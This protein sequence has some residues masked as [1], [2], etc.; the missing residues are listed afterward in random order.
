MPVI[1]D[2]PDWW[3]RFTEDGLYVHKFSLPAQQVFPEHKIANVIEEEF[4]SHINQP[5]DREVAKK[6]KHEVKAGI[7]MLQKSSD[8]GGVMSQQHLVY[9]A[10]HGLRLLGGTTSPSPAWI[11][12][13][14]CTNLRPAY[15]MSFD[16]W[17]DKIANFIQAGSPFREASGRAI[18]LKMLPQ[19]WQLM[20]EEKRE[21]L[22][23]VVYSQ[24]QGQYT[25]T[26]VCGR[27]PGDFDFEN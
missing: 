25:H 14:R 20:E 18:K 21:E 17:I 3:V 24:Y 23:E 13:S 5:F 1:L 12:S 6:G 26:W 10:L 11:V 22:Y 7:A 27:V 15:R 9:C 8:V 16:L 19:W 2:H 4:S